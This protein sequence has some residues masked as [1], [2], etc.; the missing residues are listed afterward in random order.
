M[1]II[2]CTKSPAV[3]PYVVIA[4]G[5]VKGCPQHGTIEL[6]S[7]KECTACSRVE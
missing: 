3:C 7:C 5:M 1:T 6:D 2:R 4:T